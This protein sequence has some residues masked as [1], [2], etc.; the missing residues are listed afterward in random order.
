KVDP[1]ININPSQLKD[2]IKELSEDITE[3][4]LETPFPS[5]NNRQFKDLIS[6]SEIDKKYAEEIRD[7]FLLPVP[8]PIHDKKYN[9]CHFLTGTIMAFDKLV[10]E[11]GEIKTIQQVTDQDKSKE[12]Y[13]EI[14]TMM[15]DMKKIEQSEKI[16]SLLS[17]T[18]SHTRLIAAL[19][20]IMEKLDTIRTAFYHSSPDVKIDSD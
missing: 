11:S 7:K 16:K 8:T 6:F 19:K 12:I 5:E 1:E 20:Q 15:P 9:T 4:I 18:E 3:A 10:N 13:K 14:N 17:D 2:Y